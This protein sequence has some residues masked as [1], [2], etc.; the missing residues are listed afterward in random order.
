MKR[1]MA[2]ILT[3]LMVLGSL[4][5]FA[6]GKGYNIGTFTTQTL[7]GEDVDQTLFANYK[8]N[9]VNV[10]GT[11]CKPCIAEMPDLGRIHKE[12]AAKGV[13]VVG[14]VSDAMKVEGNVVV[15]DEEKAEGLW[16]KLVT[17]GA[18]YTHIMPNMDLY[19][20]LIRYIDVVPTTLFL[21]SEGN[22]VGYAYA[23]YR[24]YDDWVKII[25]EMLKKIPAEV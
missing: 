3:C 24:S 18:E 7:Q 5:A 2:A 4:T 23:G 9:M 11:Y 15:P 1:T 13:Q 14:V 21:D 22:Q 25:D 8:L 6:A 16:D 12:Y 10:W 17:L 20:N 19:I